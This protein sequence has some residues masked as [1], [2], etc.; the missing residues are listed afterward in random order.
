MASIVG[1]AALV[2]LVLGLVIG[3][4]VG[5]VILVADLLTLGAAAGGAVVVATAVR[6]AQA[7]ALKGITVVPA[8]PTDHARLHNLTE[9]LCST[10]GLSKPALLVVD[11]PAANAAALATTATDASLVV[12]AGLLDVLDRVELEGVLAYHLRRIRDQEALVG[13]R[14]VP[15]ASGLATRLPVLA[16]RVAPALGTVDDVFLDDRAAVDVT[17]YPPGLVGALGK[18]RDRGADV[19]GANPLGAHLWLVPPAAGSLLELPSID[20]RI[21]A[22]REL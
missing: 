3:V 14:A 18:I 16:P 9:G 22:L 8:D 10:L 4:A 20:D 19:P 2:G 21:A 7:V 15:F 1:A 17:R 6:N 12:T 11:V 5:A 13:T